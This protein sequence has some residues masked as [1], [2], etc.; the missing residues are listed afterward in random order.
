[1][2]NIS[3]DVAVQRNAGL[4]YDADHEWMLFAENLALNLL[5]YWVLLRR[6][7]ADQVAGGDE[8]LVSARVSPAEKSQP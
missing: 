4:L 7:L 6:Q 2:R 8:D 5:N 1:V 3:R